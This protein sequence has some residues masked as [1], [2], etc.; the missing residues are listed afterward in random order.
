MRWRFNGRFFIPNDMR[1]RT[2]REIT[3]ALINE[4][5]GVVV[6]H[7]DVFGERMA[8][9][10]L[11]DLISTISYSS[12]CLLLSRIAAI[13]ASR[14]KHNME[15]QIQL[16]Q[17]IFDQETL[18]RIDS[19]NESSNKITFTDWQIANLVKI[20]LLKSSQNPITSDELSANKEP[21]GLCLLGINDYF[22][23]RSLTDTYSRVKDTEVNPLYEALIRTYCS[24]TGENS[25]HILARYYD[26]YFKLPYTPEG[27]AI[28]P[29]VDIQREFQA[30][31][32]VSLEAYMAIGFGFYAKYATAGLPGKQGAEGH[33]SLE[34]DDFL[35]DRRSFFEKMEIPANQKD[36]ILQDFCVNATDFRTEHRK[37][38]QDTSGLLYDFTIFKQRPLVALNEYKLSPV[39]I[40]WLYEKL[41]EGCFWRINDGIEEPEKRSEFRRFFGPLYQL[42][43]QRV[44]ERLYPD[45]DFVQRVTYDQEENGQRSSDVILSY[46]NQLVLFEAKWP[47]LRMDATM[48]PGSIEAFD[49]D[50]DDIITR[51]ARQLDRNI[52]NIIGGRLHLK[53][54]EAEKIT[55][56]Y[57]VVIVARPFPIGPAL[58]PYI[59]DKV[60]ARNLL[61]Q[62]YTKPL[63]IISC[64]ELEFIEPLIAQGTT[65]PEILEGKWASPYHFYNM[66]WYLYNIADKR[67]QAR[68]EYINGLFNEFTDKSRNIMFGT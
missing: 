49:K 31:T 61:K 9:D 46:P 1:V 45:S 29:F 28:R 21:I 39:V 55:T 13:L 67:K 14:G 32:G 47:N 12:W 38:Y 30:I 48:I 50:L 24:Q 66:K 65:F 54:V 58:T 5:I 64:E 40:D 15:T 6:T 36:L 20:A 63:E 43:I 57:P 25:R 37:K 53:N 33:T 44:F 41:G 3:Q 17:M 7:E 68:N 34:A 60:A 59:L 35:I 8:A 27:M 51:A 2:R 23:S 19:I 16:A 62:P 18:E 4:T 56:S 26:L 10:R 11:Q 52:N 42:Y 22:G